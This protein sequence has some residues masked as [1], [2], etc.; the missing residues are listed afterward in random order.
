MTGQRASEK[1]YYLDI[2]VKV[3][4]SCLNA[5]S[6][7]LSISIW[8]QRLGHVNNKTI[9][10][11]SKENAAN[12]LKIE[13]T[14]NPPTLCHGCILGKMHRSSFPNERTRKNH[15][16]DLIHSDVCGPMQTMSP[17]KSRYYVLFK[18]DFSGWCE[19]Q[20][21]KNKSEVF[22][23]FQNFVAAFKTQYNHIVRILRSDGGG[24][25]IGQEFEEWLKKNGTNLHIIHVNYD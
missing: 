10:K 8:H 1:L 21:M 25:Y 6:R 12:G 9:L 20:F 7:P 4:E 22:H 3:Q 11:M 5:T 15:V 14:S 23:H 19:V 18:D 17:G 24:E 2:T 16:G 13:E